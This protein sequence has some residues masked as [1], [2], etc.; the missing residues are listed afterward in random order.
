MWF[1]CALAQRVPVGDRRS[2]PFSRPRT[3]AVP[4]VFVMRIGGVA[5]FRGL[6]PRVP[7]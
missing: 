3:L 1:R 2:K 5:L 6:R 7:A 4:G